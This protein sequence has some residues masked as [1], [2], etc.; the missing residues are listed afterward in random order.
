MKRF[1]TIVLTLA[2]VMPSTVAFA[3]DGSLETLYGACIDQKITNCDRKA[4]RFCSGCTEIRR[5]A[6]VA[7]DQAQFYRDYKNQLMHAM[8]EQNVGSKRHQVDHFLINVYFDAKSKSQF[9]KTYLET[10][11]S[12][13][14]R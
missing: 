11:P 9:A 2:L 7:K 14:V 6:L 3:G 8:A 12:T 10:S 13:V 5:D 4:S 1:V